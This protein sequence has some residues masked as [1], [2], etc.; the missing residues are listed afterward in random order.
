[1]A[2]RPATDKEK[3]AFRLFERTYDT[4]VAQLRPGDF[5]S[6]GKLIDKMEAIIRRNGWTTGPTGELMIDES[7]VW[8][9]I[10][11]AN[12]QPDIL[13]T[14]SDGLIAFGWKNTKDFLDRMMQ[15]DYKP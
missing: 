10:R 4:K 14:S 6:L 2:H 7:I 13:E 5:V 8:Q 11:R 1:M 9:D 15:K 3:Q 12:P